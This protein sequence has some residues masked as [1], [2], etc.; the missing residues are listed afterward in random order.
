MFIAV[1][2]V[3][4]DDESVINQPLIEEEVVVGL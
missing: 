3:A 1:G 2:D 4:L